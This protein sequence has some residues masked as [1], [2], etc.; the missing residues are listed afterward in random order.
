MTHLSNITK[1]QRQEMVQKSKEKRA[2]KKAWAEA[3]LKLDWAD[4]QHWRELAS[5]Y[6][7]RM[8]NKFEKASGKFVNRFLK[9]FNLDK[10][11]YVLS[12]GLKNGNEEA[13]LNPKLPAFAQVGLLLEQYNEDIGQG[14]I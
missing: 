9:H 4:E 14:R 5:K 7:Y 1:E 3:N 10:E 12:T 11:F 13:R 8:P 6:G 2:Q